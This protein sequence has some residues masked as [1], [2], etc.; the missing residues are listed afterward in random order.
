VRPF[1]GGAGAI[2]VL[3]RVI[4]AAEHSAFQENSALEITPEDLRDILAWVH[5]SQLETI[6]L[7]E[8][9][10]RLAAPTGRKFICFTFDDGYRD[11][12]VH[13]LPIF[14]D[15]NIPL[16]VNVTNGFVDGTVSVW[17]YLLEQALTAGRE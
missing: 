17:W 1:F 16:A 10:A 15:F 9:P 4:P 7:D 12:L 5:A 6:T 11:N 13:A 2:V 14:R 8:V 3:H